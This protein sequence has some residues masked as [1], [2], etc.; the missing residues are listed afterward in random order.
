MRAPVFLLTTAWRSLIKHKGRSLLTILSIIVGIATVIATMAIGR[1][2]QEKIRRRIASMGNNVLTIY[3][4]QM[5]QSGNTQQKKRTQRKDLREGDIA[6]FKEISPEI[7]YISGIGYSCDEPCKYRNNHMMVR[8]TMCHGDLLR[9]SK[10]NLAYGRY[11]SSQEDRHGGRVCI[12]GS[13]AA[14]QLFKATPPLGKQL[15]INKYPF[16]VI[17]VL[18]SAESFGFFE[19]KNNDIFIPMA[20]GRRLLNHWLIPD[21]VHNIQLSGYEGADL[22]KLER[23]LSRALRAR[24]QLSGNVPDDFTIVNQ[25]SMSAAAEQS[26]QTFNLFLLIVASLSLLVGGIGVSNIMLV[27]VTERTKEIGIRLALG[28]PPRMI[29]LQFLIESILLCGIGGLFGIMLGVCAPFVAT[30]FTDWLV[31]ITP[32]SILASFIITVAIGVVFG[33]LPAR[34]AALM[35]IVEALHDR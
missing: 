26:S 13:E 34:R 2:A 21:R 27:S 28:A 8:P 32:L 29:L 31:I 24:H 25:S 5:P 17:G 6:Y 11:F 23:T 33:F 7:Q 22:K 9:I 1:G 14:K 35:N 18:N 16:T 20:T 3:C 30:F 15:L 12:I 10:R 4:F 19:N